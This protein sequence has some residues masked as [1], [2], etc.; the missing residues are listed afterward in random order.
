MIQPEEKLTY[1]KREVQ[2]Y[3]SG[4]RVV[5]RDY[6]TKRKTDLNSAIN[7]K[8]GKITEYTPRTAFRLSLHLSEFGDLYDNEITLTYPSE[9]PMNGE[10]VRNHRKLILEKLKYNGMKEYT[11]CLEF[12]S[13][14]A[15][16][17]HILTDLWIPK[18]KLKKL[19]F[20]TVGSGDIEH[21]KQGARIKQIKDMT[22]TKVYMSSY[23]KKK[24][25][26]SVPAGYENVGKWWTSNRSAKPTLIE[27]TQYEDQKNL[28]RA[29]RNI[30]RWRR[31]VKRRVQQNNTH[32]KYKAWNIK[33]GRGFFAWG[34]PDKIQDLIL[35]LST[36]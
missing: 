22:L 13:R 10:I 31:S 29:N 8:R 23:A 18:G 35:R 19:W 16:H 17:I 15:P 25:Q 24:D 27:V 14:G 30:T 1:P 28:M 26:K 5:F 2:F 7:G 32:K 9:Y 20:Q 34:K 12:Q 36:C 11:T 21:L 3:K 4:T 6:Y 33:N